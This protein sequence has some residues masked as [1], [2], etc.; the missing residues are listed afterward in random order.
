MMDIPG[1]S[2]EALA[3]VEQLL[4]GEIPWQKQFEDGKG[5]SKNN[6]ENY[7]TGLSKKKGGASFSSPA[8]ES[9]GTWANQNKMNPKCCPDQPSKRGLATLCPDR[10]KTSKGCVNWG[11]TCRV[12]WFLCRVPNLPINSAKVL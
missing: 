10:R 5:P 1:F 6:P 12:G 8:R 3:S 7:H 9:K 11:K 4:Y 2:S